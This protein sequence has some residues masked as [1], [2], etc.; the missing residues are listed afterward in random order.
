MSRN[1][2]RSVPGQ[3]LKLGVEVSSEILG[4]LIS[5][6]QLYATGTAP[7]GF[8]SRS[9]RRIQPANLYAL[10]HSTLSCPSYARGDNEVRS[11][12]NRAV[13]A[14]LLGLPGNELVL[15]LSATCLTEVTPT[16]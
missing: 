4:G 15:L 6:G 8:T 3:M 14:T 5:K 1:D 13:R 9:S 16:R 7:L 12:T 2:V 10:W 11:T